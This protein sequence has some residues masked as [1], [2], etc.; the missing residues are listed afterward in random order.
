MVYWYQRISIR[1]SIHLN[2]KKQQSISPIMNPGKAYHVISVQE[3]EILSGIN[4][5]PKM[6][7]EKKTQLLNLPEPKT[8]K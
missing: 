6:S 5:F 3:L 1:L 4:F 2:N 7:E 8:Y